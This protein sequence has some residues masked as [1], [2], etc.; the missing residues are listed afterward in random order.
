MQEIT[1]EVTR[2]DGTT[3]KDEVYQ[4]VMKE[5][6]NGHSVAPEAVVSLRMTYGG[7]EIALLTLPAHTTK[8]FLEKQTM[9]VNWL[10][11]RVQEVMRPTKCFKCWQCSH[12]SKKCTSQIDRSKCCIKVGEEGYKAEKCTATP[13]CS[14]CKEACNKETNHVPRISRCPVYKEA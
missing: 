6:G 10:N 2:L 11:V 14:L 1:L 13:C 8:K 12:I 3:T 5:L 7:I 4:A 9:R